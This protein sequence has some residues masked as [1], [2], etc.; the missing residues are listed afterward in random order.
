MITYTN[1]SM[2]SWGNVS[3]QQFLLT[4]AECMTVTVML[5]DYYGE[6]VTILLGQW[7]IYETEF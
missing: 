3:L 7:A 6:T 2:K 1:I 5:R 4:R